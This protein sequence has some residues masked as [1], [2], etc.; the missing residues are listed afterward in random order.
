MVF[1]NRN[2]G[3]LLFEGIHSQD[4]IPNLIEKVIGLTDESFEEKLKLFIEVEGKLSSF[5]MDDINEM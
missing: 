2:Y 1:L 3:T 5:V 4:K